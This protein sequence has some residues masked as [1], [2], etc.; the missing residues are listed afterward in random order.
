MMSVCWKRIEYQYMGTY[1]FCLSTVRIMAIDIHTDKLIKP[2]RLV[3]FFSSSA[4]LE[5][6]PQPY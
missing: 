5:R 1:F 4:Q 6:C 3:S 2:S